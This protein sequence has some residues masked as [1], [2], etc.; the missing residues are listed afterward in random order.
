M[1]FLFIL[2]QF[3]WENATRFSRENRFTLFLALL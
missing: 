3:P 1:R 2:T